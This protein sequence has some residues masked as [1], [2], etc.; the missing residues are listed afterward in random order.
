[1]VVSICKNPLGVF[2]HNPSFTIQSPIPQHTKTKFKKPA[3]I[4]CM[5]TRHKRGGCSVLLVF[6]G[7][8]GV[9]NHTFSFTFFTAL[10]IVYTTYVYNN[11]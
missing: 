11:R 5:V 3:Q 9:L 6:F 4:L 10:L 8:G 7:A 2:L 1:M